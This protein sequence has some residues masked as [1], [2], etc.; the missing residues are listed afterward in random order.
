PRLSCNFASP[1]TTAPPPRPPRA[2]H[3]PASS[4][5]TSE[6]M[7]PRRSHDEPDVQAHIHK[8]AHGATPQDTAD[9]VPEL[10]RASTLP[11]GGLDDPSSPRTNLAP[12]ASG[13]RTPSSVRSMHSREGAFPPSAFIQPRAL[14][15]RVPVSPSTFNLSPNAIEDLVI[16]LDK[17]TEK[18]V[19]DEVPLPSKGAAL[20]RDKSLP[21]IVRDDSDDVSTSPP[22]SLSGGVKSLRRHSEM[23]PSRSNS[24]G[25]DAP[26]SSSSSG[27][28]LN[29]HHSM[30]LR[31]AASTSRASPSPSP[32]SSRDELPEIPQ[33]ERNRAYPRT[34]SSVSLASASAIQ[35]IPTYDST[36]TVTG[37]RKRR[38]GPD[39]YPPTMLFQDIL[40]RKT[41]IDRYTAYAQRFNGLMEDSSGIEEWVHFMRHRHKGAIVCTTPS[42]I[43]LTLCSA[44]VPLVDHNA[45]Q[46]VALPVRMQVQRHETGASVSSEF[47]IRPDSYVAVA[48]DLTPT[49][50]E[51]FTPPTGPPPL[52]YPALAN[53]P[54]RPLQNPQAAMNALT[55]PTSTSLSLMPPKATGG[56]FSSISRKTSITRKLANEGNQLL[57]SRLTLRK[58]NAPP[59]QPRPVHLG[60]APS[61]PGGPRA[62]GPRV[63]RS[64]T[65]G[66]AEMSQRLAK[67]GPHA[68]PFG[69]RPPPGTVSS[70]G[71]LASGMPAPATNDAFTRSL[72]GMIDILPHVDRPTLAL[73]LRRA[74][75]KE[76]NAI[77]TYLADEKAGRV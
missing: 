29:K 30:D 2:S 52:P 28:A 69:A 37:K 15:Q 45:A 54:I 31:F 71:L 34:P 7:L 1:L 56:F 55:S 4:R 65:V 16:A 63:M 73:Y 50:E 6:D 75:G 57:G 33:H 74:D 38:G 59:P 5:S 70:G 36:L 49:R 41:P 20:R 47:P 25:L 22:A 3:S 60:V 68:A 44:P 66:G 11:V 53:G 61:I 67:G 64:N 32:S 23:P 21:R 42:R 35:H 48:V 43:D 77:S 24:S 13:S 76:I 72:R 10:L 51:D 46:V 40:K 14:P 18:Q 27:S 39:S 26:P 12:T 19:Q 8:H 17:E 9:E 62:P 58:Q